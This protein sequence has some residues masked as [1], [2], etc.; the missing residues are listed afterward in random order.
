MSKPFLDVLPRPS[1]LWPGQR[2]LLVHDSYSVLLISLTMPFYT[3]AFWRGA[4]RNLNQVRAGNYL[5]VTPDRDAANLLYRFI[6]DEH[7]AMQI[8][9]SSPQYWTFHGDLDIRDVFQ[10]IL[11]GGIAINN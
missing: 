1:F 5:I 8:K 9:R 4:N 10:G 7:K 3:L 6:H 2:Y 11:C